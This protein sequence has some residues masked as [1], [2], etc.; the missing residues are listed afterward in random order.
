MKTYENGSTPVTVPP[1]VDAKFSTPYGDV[2]IV[3]V[4]E[5][6]IGYT[7]KDGFL[8]SENETSGGVLFR[9]EGKNWPSDQWYQVVTV[10]KRG[11]RIYSDFGIR[12]P[13][14]YLLE[15]GRAELIRPHVDLADIQH[16]ELRPRGEYRKFVLEDI[17]LPKTS[18]AKFIA[19]PKVVVTFNEVNSEVAIT[20]LKP[21]DLRL[22]LL[23]GNSVN[24]GVGDHDRQSTTGNLASLGDELTLIGRL[25]GVGNLKWTI[26][27][28]P[29]SFRAGAT[30]SSGPLG[31]KFSALYRMSASDL[32]AVII[33][34]SPP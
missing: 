5:G 8:V 18:M 26:T 33:E 25:R 30:S 14:S 23:D 2:R 16:F 28:Q 29:D 17:R 7:Q 27:T 9:F 11:Q 3:R 24:E 22:Q 20:E 1:T 31:H 10:T 4:I 12:F 32:K 21:L 19:P 6:M 13:G 15:D 34:F